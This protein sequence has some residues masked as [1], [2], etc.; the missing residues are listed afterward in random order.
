MARHGRSFIF[1]SGL[2]NASVV[3]PKPNLFLPTGVRSSAV[4]AV[5]SIRHHQGTWARMTKLKNARV[6]KIPLFLPTAP[7]VMVAVKQ[8]RDVRKLR[9]TTKLRPPTIVNPKPSLFLPTG[10]HSRLN[11]VNRALRVRRNFKNSTK[12]SGPTV[13]NR[14]PAFLPTGVH[15]RLMPT[16]MS[17]LTRRNFKNSTRLS[18]PTIVNYPAAF[19]PTGPHA[20]VAVRRS[21]RSG[22]LRPT[23]TRLRPPTVVGSSGVVANH[24]NFFVLF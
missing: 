12:L 15:S 13:V 5:D 16:R 9:Y 21:Y 1:K 20:M 19:L 6:I 14:P 7:K 10:V 18:P 22:A 11:A 23:S 17:I 3:N 24:S 8:A 2:H 4:F